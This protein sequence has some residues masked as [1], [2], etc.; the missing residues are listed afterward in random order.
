MPISVFFTLLALLGAALNW[1]GR[2]VDLLNLPEDM[3]SIGETLSNLETDWGLWIFFVGLGGLIISVL[4]AFQKNK[5]HQTAVVTGS[6]Q[7]SGQAPQIDRQPINHAYEYLL[8]MGAWKEGDEPLQI[9]HCLRQAALDGGITIW[10]AEP[11]SLPFERQLPLLLEIES[12][13]WEHH[14]IN[15]VCL[16]YS[17]SELPDKGCF[18]LYTGPIHK[19]PD[20]RW[21]LHVDMNEIKAKW[22]HM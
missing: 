8:E 12:G 20:V 4:I 5:T 7:N 13:Y 6:D 19:A 15:P 3:E 17:A 9:A 21:H 16:M 11:S 18:T 10:G 14:E 2:I 1:W 22:P